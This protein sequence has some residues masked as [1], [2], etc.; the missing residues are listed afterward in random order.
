MALEFPEDTALASRYVKQALPMMIKNKIAPNPCNFALWYAYVSNRD[1]LLNKKLDT[2]LKEK[3]TCPEVVS[4]D[5]FKKHVI[6]EEIAL[7]KNLQ[8]S[9]SNVVQELVGNVNNTKNQTNTYNQYLETSLTEIL[10]DPDPIHVQETVKNLIKTTKDASHLANDFQSQLQSAEEEIAALKQQLDQREED[11]YLD[12]LTKVGNRRAFD[13]RLVEL[14]QTT[15]NDT[16]L[17]L[18]DLD[19]FKKLNDTYGHLMG[20]KVLQ[21]VAKVMQKAC[22][23]NALAARYGGEEFAF[24]IQG[25][26]D[27]GANIAEHTRQLLGKLLLRKKSDGQV[28][29][30]ITAS[31]GVVQRNDG[32]YPEQLIERADKAL[33]QAKEAGR[34]R[35]KMA[36]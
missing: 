19:H 7:Q 14:F 6:K 21:G 17:V 9:L 3:G 16:T 36:A 8:D 10:A 1:L 35:V 33:Y 4:R 34:N 20:D 28:I 32:E 27:I 15:D 30:N 11:A 2:T 5:L 12:A 18:V 24:L 22:P 29:D 25:N 31:F 26:A 13:R 23:D